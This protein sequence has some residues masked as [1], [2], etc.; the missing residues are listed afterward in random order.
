M[1]ANISKNVHHCCNQS[2]IIT[3]IIFTLNLGSITTAYYRTAQGIILTYDV[4]NPESFENLKIWAKG[5]D[6]YA[7]KSVSCI[8]V[9]NKCDLV[10][11]QQISTEKGKEL[12]NK[13]GIQFFET[14]AKNATSVEEAFL[15]LARDIKMIMVSDIAKKIAK[16][17][18]FTHHLVPA[19]LCLTICEILCLSTNVLPK[20]VQK[21]LVQTILLVGINAN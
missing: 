16:D 12:A 15:T 8:L 5:I 11:K 10:D 7:A 1:E 14:S 4:T 6:Q 18:P 3:Q 13:Y 21:Y 9:G 20:D 19:H 2:L 17:W